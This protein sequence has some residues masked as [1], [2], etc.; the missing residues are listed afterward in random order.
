M[1]DTFADRLAEML[2]PT[3][4]IERE[5]GG[6]GMS[7][8]FLARDSSLGRRVV[9]KVLPPDLAAGVNTERFRREIVVAA[10]LMH[11]HI[12]PVHS[13]AQTPDGVLYYSM[14]F[15]EG[16]SMRARLQD[17]PIPLVQSIRFLR[18]IASALSHAHA[19]GLV[20]RDMK[21]ENVLLSG[22]YALVADFGIA[23]A[24]HSAGMGAL[25]SSTPDALTSIGVALGTP[26]YMA[27]EQVAGDVDIDA[28]ADLYA[29]G[30]IAYELVCGQVP[31]AGK[32]PRAMLVAHLATEPEPLGTLV[33]DVPPA[34]EAIIMQCLAKEP[35]DRPPSAQAIVEALETLL[36]ADPRMSSMDARASV[37][38][39]SPSFPRSQQLS[40]PVQASVPPIRSRTNAV[41]V[42][43][44]IATLLV[45]AGV[46]AWVRM[47]GGDAL[48]DRIA[49]TSIMVEAEDRVLVD[50]GRTVTETLA[51]A[52]AA[53]DSVEVASREEV[54]RAEDRESA[55]ASPSALARLLRS[56]L[57]VTGR[58]KAAGS[59]SVKVS[60]QLLDGR[61]ATIQTLADLTVPRDGLQRSIV[62]LAD[63]VAAAAR[64]VTDSTFG[65]AMLPKGS[66]PTT[67]ALRAVA[68]GLAL[69]AGIRTPEA[70]DDK[71]S[72]DLSRFDAAVLEDPEY[73]QARL[74]FASAAV[75]RFGGEALADSVLVLI[76]R[77][78]LTTYERSL[79]DALQADVEG[80]HELSLRSWRTASQL[81]PSWPNRWWLSMKLRDVNRPNESLGIL[82]TLGLQ[83]PALLRWTPSIH[84]FIG[85]FDAE[86]RAVEA[87]ATRAPA[88]ANSLGVQQTLLQA[89]AGLGRSEEITH[90]LVDVETLPAEA[91]TSVA[92]LLTRTAWELGA[93]E[94]PAMRDDAMKRAAAWCDRRSPS[95]LRDGALAFDCLEAYALIGRTGELAALA[96]PMLQARRD[97]IMVL[98]LL[99]LAAALRSERPLAERFAAQIE[100]QTRP[101]GGRGLGWW[102]RARIAAALGDRDEAVELLRD[103][104]ARGAGWSQRLDLHRDPAFVKLR[105]YAPFERLR[106][107]Q[108]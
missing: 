38:A 60:L 29:L 107:P 28:R 80:N 95:D 47:R 26:A 86:L 49:V 101:G 92:H 7:R 67:A 10:G 90:R 44:I 36:T 77:D 87:E 46:T 63:R 89:L 102:L 41:L 69:E 13:A 79:M 21:P 1:R 33:T 6:G 34:L 19:N 81:A 57:L 20:H 35:A 23:K 11:P 76:D 108:G 56:R 24:L 85:S 62:P 99:G 27:P 14:P 2:A 97:D 98:G 4:I 31:F 75:R 18:D 42:G 68:D 37:A 88:T 65:Q 73:Q 74:W 84:H 54:M 61:G 82:K 91:G 64:I 17:G 58:L 40:T 12:V 51:A 71:E 55:A 66:P 53:L 104:F 45:A 16:Q 105:G 39:D 3:Y 22:G 94:L 103:A 100:V 50:A 52:V 30:I 8:V 83:Q 48:E 59:D 72:A 5:L 25:T 32:S 96:E 93:H 78:R 15:I 70:G 43:A 106:T 9:L